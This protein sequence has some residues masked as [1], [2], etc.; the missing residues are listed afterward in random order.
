[1]A[2]AVVRDAIEIVDKRQANTSRQ[3]SLQKQLIR[4]GDERPDLQNH[5]RP[6]LDHLSTKTAMEQNEQEQVVR[7]STDEMQEA[8]EL[9]DSAFNKLNRIEL[10]PEP[11]RLVVEVAE[12]RDQIQELRRKI[13]NNRYL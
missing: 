9:M 13:K 4:L 7:R 12:L 6:V 11:D 8:S 1:M 10:L 2:H 3:S 5:L